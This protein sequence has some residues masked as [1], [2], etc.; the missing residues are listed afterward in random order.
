MAIPRKCTNCEAAIEFDYCARCGQKV[1]K[2]ENR[3]IKVLMEDFFANFFFLDNRIWRS[4]IYLLFKPG[5]I[6]LEYLEGKRKKFLS[7]IS[8]FLFVNLLY[9][10]IDPSADYHLEL[11]DQVKL[12]PYSDIAMQMVEKEVAERGVF[13]YEYEA[14]YNSKTTQ[15]SKLFMIANVPVIALLIYISVFRIRKYYYDSLIFSFHFFTFFLL[16]TIVGNILA[17]LLDVIDSL[18]FALIVFFVYTLLSIRKFVNVKWYFSILLGLYAY[19]TIF[20]A[21]LFYRAFNFLVTFYW[22]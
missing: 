5:K 7:P 22:I 4:T 10:I 11:I 18:S 21:M 12:Q 15:L 14:L 3:S 13:F 6:S 2:A 20:F 1:L 17:S 16:T 9:F 8:L 19:L